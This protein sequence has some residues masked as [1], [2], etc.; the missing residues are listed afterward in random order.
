MRTSE[1]DYLVEHQLYYGMPEKTIEIYRN[2]WLHTGDLATKDEDGFFYFVDRKQDAIRRRGENISS[3]EVEAAVNSHPS[4]LESAAFPVKSTVSEDDTM[5]VAVLKP[6]KTLTPEAF[7]EHCVAKMP[8]FW[9]P[10]YVRLTWDPLP[11]TLTNKVEKY[12]LRDQGVTPDTWDREK[13]G[14]Q[15]TRG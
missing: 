15:V 8:C 4:I 12:R 1:V 5:V 3:F 9:V 14:F 2:F 10:R 11:R 7:M 6:D 13:V